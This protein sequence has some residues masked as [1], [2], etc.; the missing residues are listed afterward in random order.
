VLAEKWRCNHFVAEGASE[1]ISFS[2]RSANPGNI[3]VPPVRT[4]F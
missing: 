1:T 3:V 4:I 2:I